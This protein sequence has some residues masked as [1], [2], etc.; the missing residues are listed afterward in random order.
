MSKKQQHDVGIES[1]SIVPIV[2]DDVDEAI[3]FY[4]EKL[5][6]EVRADET[7]ELEGSE[8]RWVT[9]GVP[10]D[11]LQFDVMTADEP[12]YSDERRK[13][14]ESKRGTETYYTFRTQDCRASVEALEAAGVEITQEPRDEAWGT[15]A[16]FADPT[17][18]EFALYQPA[19]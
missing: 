19:S 6:F 3:E 8:G 9:V 17:G 1:V 18:N 15:M 4:T 5:G 2:V 12:Y 14:L 16:R 7:F 10:G 13:L 11:H